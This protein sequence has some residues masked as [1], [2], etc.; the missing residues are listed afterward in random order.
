MNLLGHQDV[1]AV[2]I[3][4]GRKPNA[5]AFDGGGPSLKCWNNSAQCIVVTWQ[6]NSDNIF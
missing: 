5:Y 6:F 2:L 3:N 1:M 4:R